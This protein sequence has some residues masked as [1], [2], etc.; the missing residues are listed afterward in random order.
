M[1]IG[2]TSTRQPPISTGTAYEPMAMAKTSSEPAST[3]GIDIGKVI[4][5]KVRQR[6][7]A[8]AARR[9]LQ[10][11]IDPLDDADQ[12]EDHE[13]Q[14]E[15]HH[16][17][18]AR[19]T[20]CTSAAADRRSRPSVINVSLISPASPIRIMKPVHADDQV[21]LHR[22][23]DQDHVEVGAARARLL[24]HDIGERIAQQQG[25]HGR[26]QGEDDRADQ[27]PPVERSARRSGRRSRG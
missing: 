24:G 14:G 1:C 20:R 15:L 6:L 18:D 9:L 23:Q 26:N 16:A 8:E 5:K 12:R 7:G 10:R 25:E 21:E 19:R 13:R 4:V 2:I 22:G 3:P 11:R 27:R 17:D